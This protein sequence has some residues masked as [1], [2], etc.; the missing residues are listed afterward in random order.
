[1]LLSERW[2]RIA[3]PHRF[4]DSPNKFPLLLFAPPTRRIQPLIPTSTS[5]DMAKSKSKR[6]QESLAIDAPFKKLKT[7]AIVTPP[8]EK[9]ASQPKTIQSIG[10]DNDDLDTAIDT[11]NTLAENPGVIKSKACKDLRTAVYEFR[12]AC[13]TG[14]NASGIAPLPRANC[15]ANPQ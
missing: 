10:L 12:Q 15:R 14:F 8:P 13:T 9:D 3:G 11:L 1:V 5:I 4:Q 7:V 2:L 6:K